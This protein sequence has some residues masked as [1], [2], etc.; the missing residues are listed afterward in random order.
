MI[1]K[2]SE[3]LI[4]RVS[5][6][7]K[8]YKSSGELDE[9]DFYRWIKE[10]LMKLNVPA[11]SPVHRIIEFEESK[12]EIPQDLYRI[13][14]MWKYDHV[15]VKNTNW[16]KTNQI[17]APIATYECYNECGDP[18]EVEKTPQYLTTKYF[19]PTQQIT[20]SYTNGQLLQL[21]NYSVEKCDKDSPSIYNKSSLEVTMDNNNFY[22]NFEA[23]SVYLQYFKVMLD[24]NGLPMIPDVVQ[25]E[26]AIETYIVFR[27]FQ[28]LFYE[29]SEV[30]GK[31]QYA[32]Q[33][34]YEALKI[35][36]NWVKL[37]KA[38]GL[39]NYLKTVRDKYNI[40]EF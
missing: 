37:P 7:L 40:F 27:F 18:C 22:F 23:G 8:S 3:Q 29:N 33:K 17:V 31:M 34:H 9:G 24:E 11:F 35:A 1:F 39:I 19:L 5:K 14:A 12:L 28:E 15:E 30:I 25:I 6:Q 20:R 21:K 36:T 38:Q 26:L 2:S 4:A 32:E 10:I 16:I 13:W